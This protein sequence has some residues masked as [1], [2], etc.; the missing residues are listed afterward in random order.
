[1]AV[2]PDEIK[3]LIIQAIPDA[4]VE[5]R[6]YSGDDHFEAEVVSPAFAGTTKVAQHKMVY[7]ALGDRMRSAIHAL[8]L[9]TH[10]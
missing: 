9:N 4:T 5:V 3:R 8:R 2:H 10:T 7:A 6:C 1:M